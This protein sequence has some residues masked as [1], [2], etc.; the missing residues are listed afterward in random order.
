MMFRF[1]VSV[2]RVSSE[3][4][5]WPRSA[6]EIALAETPASWASW[7]WLSWRCMRTARSAPPSRAAAG[8]WV[9]SGF[10]S[11]SR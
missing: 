9:S 10:P 11:A 5:R 7:A 2:S 4:P 1:A 8:A 6:C 3:S